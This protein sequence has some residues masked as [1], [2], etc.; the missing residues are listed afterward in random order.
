MNCM[1]E[2]WSNYDRGHNRMCS[3]EYILHVALSYEK[4]EDAG[5]NVFDLLLASV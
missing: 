2:F 3:Q 4:S 5:L 1:T